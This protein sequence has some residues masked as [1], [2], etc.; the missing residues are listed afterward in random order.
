V[1]AVAAAASA[2]L[3]MVFLEARKTALKIQQAL[4]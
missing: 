1:L 4:R 2:N 3:G